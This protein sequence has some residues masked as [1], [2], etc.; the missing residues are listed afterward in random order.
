MAD[1]QTPQV[2]TEPEVV[3]PAPAPAPVAEQV[4]EAVPAVAQEV[5]PQ[6]EEDIKGK[7]V[8]SKGRK[9]LSVVLI[10]LLLLLCG[11]GLLILKLFMPNGTNKS[12][13]SGVTWI[14]SIYG[15]GPQNVQL[16]NPSGCAIDS[17]D[18]TFWM[19]DT[20]LRRIVHYRMDGT[21]I[22]F[23]GKSKFQSDSP[24]RHPSD[25][26]I[27]SEGK[28]YVVESTYNDVLVFNAA[29]KQLGKF[30]V[31]QPTAIAVNDKYIVVG[32]KAGFVIM[33]KNAKILKLMGSLG[34]GEGQFDTV[35][36][37]AIDKE[38]NIY[39]VDTYNNRVSKYTPEG[40]LL[41]LTKTGYPGNEHT[42]LGKKKYTSKD[43]AQMQVPMG[44]TLDAAGHLLVVDM[45][46]FTIAQ[47]DAKTGKYIAKYGS[48]GTEDGKFLYSG[49]IDYDAATDTFVVSDTGNQRAQIIRLPNSGGSLLAKARSLLSG[50]LALCCIPL[51][52]I[53][54]CLIIAYILQRNRKKKEQEKYYEIALE[55]ESVIE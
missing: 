28:I 51:L 8:S 48:Y 45:F 19:A 26:A 46:D 54:I 55:K 18:G 43:A 36:G 25:I 1:E 12:A 6:A 24:I 31:P 7:T 53:I 32:A 3:A 10:I 20:N 14:R 17:R 5:Q 49:D 9:V 4:T 47:F 27:D 21:M 50:P 11:I 13:G 22:T 38:N 16:T 41:W 30:D 34:R 23:I 2:G 44:C 42:T 39:V 35:N 15:F 37:V 40:K 52:I 33:D 29:G